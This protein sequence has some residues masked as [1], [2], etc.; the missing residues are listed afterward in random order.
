MKIA[1]TKTI[2]VFISLIFISL[3]LT[4]QSYA[5]FE[6][7]SAAAIWL[8]DEGKGDLA[9]DFTGNGSDGTLTG[10]A[11]WDNG[12]FG[13]ALSLDGAASW[14]KVEATDVFALQDFTISFFVKPG[15]QDESIVA[16]IDYSHTPANW[17]VQSE[18][19]NGTK[20]WY[21]GYWGKAVAGWQVDAAG[22]VPFTEGVWQHI[23][24]VKTGKE[25]L[26]YKDGVLENTRKNADAEVGYTVASLNFGGWMG[27]SRFF[28]GLLDEV[29][30]YDGVLTEAEIKNIV[31]KGIINGASV[32]PLGKLSTAWGELKSQ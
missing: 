3:M 26:T 32:L 14:V 15:A 21:M 28:N 31:A 12:K 18:S 2:I 8:F 20:M 5:K 7:K 16:V 27:T 1:A 6:L 10:G 11:S 9:K 19:A 23:A 4:G 24:F 25:V 17:V 29:M 13:K 22:F 30:I